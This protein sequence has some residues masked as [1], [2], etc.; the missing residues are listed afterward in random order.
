MENKKPLR[1]LYAVQ[2]ITII[3]LAL[4]L[5]QEVLPFFGIAPIGRQPQIIGPGGQQLNPG[6]GSYG[7]GG[8]VSPSNQ[9]SGRTD[10]YELALSPSL[11]IVAHK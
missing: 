3:I 4:L 5:I 11:N 9:Q 8:Y 6:N 7:G 10:S 2:L 1:T